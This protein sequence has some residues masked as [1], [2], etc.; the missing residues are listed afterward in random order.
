MMLILQTGIFDT[1]WFNNGFI[2]VSREKFYK[3][4]N[5]VDDLSALALEHMLAQFF[6]L[7]TGLV[8]AAFLF[9]VEVK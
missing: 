6:L 5:L 7:G 2:E 1:Y 8:V 4:P 3:E 9:C